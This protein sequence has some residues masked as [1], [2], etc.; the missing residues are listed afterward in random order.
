MELSEDI[1]F[2]IGWGCLAQ[3]QPDEFPSVV[4]VKF[5]VRKV[6]E[7]RRAKGGIVNQQTGDN[8]RVGE[9]PKQ[10]VASC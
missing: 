9:T 2:G 3:F 6:K 4:F 7:E 5:P 1:G 10:S 8:A